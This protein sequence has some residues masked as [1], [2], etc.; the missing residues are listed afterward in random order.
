MVLSI[1]MM[2]IFD[3]DSSWRKAVFENSNVTDHEV[4]NIV[5]RKKVVI[6]VFRY[7]YKLLKHYQI[8]ILYQIMIIIKNLFF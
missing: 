2:M 1:I 8:I 6:N 3:T 7:N 5:Y 4:E